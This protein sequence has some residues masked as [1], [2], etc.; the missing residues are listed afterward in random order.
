[1]ELLIACL[2]P[3]ASVVCVLSLCAVANEYLEREHQDIETLKDDIIAL[4]SRV[5][6]I[7]VNHAEVKKQAEQVQKLISNSNLAQAFT[8]K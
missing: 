1:M 5:A 7:E 6:V 4:I 2:W 8:R 3:V